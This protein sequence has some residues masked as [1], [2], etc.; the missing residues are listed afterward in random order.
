MENDPANQAQT[1]PKPSSIVSL[2]HLF[3]SLIIS[4]SKDEHS[5][6]AEPLPNSINWNKQTNIA[7]MFIAPPCLKDLTFPHCFDNHRLTIPHSESLSAKN[8]GCKISHALKFLNSKII[9]SNSEKRHGVM[10]LSILDLF[11]FA[12]ETVLLMPGNFAR[13]ARFIAFQLDLIL[14][15]SDFKIVILTPYIHKDSADLPKLQRFESQ[16]QESIALDEDLIGHVFS[17]IKFFSI[18]KVCLDHPSSDPDTKDQAPLLQKS[19]NRYFLSPNGYQQVSIRLAQFIATWISSNRQSKLNISTPLAYTHNRI[20]DLSRQLFGPK[21]MIIDPNQVPEP[22]PAK[23]L[24]PQ[25]PNPPKASTRTGHTQ[26]APKLKSQPK[27]SPQKSSP[28]TRKRKPAAQPDPP[29]KRKQ[30]PHFPGS[31]PSPHGYFPWPP[32]SPFQP[33]LPNRRY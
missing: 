24:E 4:F 11:S 6:A 16:L 3:H 5:L 15:N 13:M 8:M 19:G 28:R 22:V 2:F 20:V 14:Q 29:A 12:E 9:E 18:L 33:Y 25:A 32:Q 10:I 27:Q 31:R 17:R 21:S 23:P 26:P 30:S 7:T 1:T